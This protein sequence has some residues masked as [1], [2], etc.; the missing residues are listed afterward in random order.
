MSWS[1][2]LHF[3]MSSVSSVLVLSAGSGYDGLAAENVPEGNIEIREL[4]VHPAPE[5]VPALKY[6]L[7]PTLPDR[8]PGNA[9]VLY[10]RILIQLPNA[11]NE[12]TSEKMAKWAGADVPLEDLPL[13]ELRRTLQPLHSV[14]GELAIA[15]R[16][17]SCQWDVPFR[18][19]QNPFAVL[20]PELQQQ[21]QLARILVVNI[22]LAIREGRI[23]DA[24]ELLQTGFALARDVGNGPTLIH[25]LVGTAICGLLT[26]EIEELALQ[27]EGPNLYW[28]LTA[29]PRPLIDLRRGLETEMH[30]LDLWFPALRDIESTGNDPSFWEAKFEEIA[31]G[32]RYATGGPEPEAGYRALLTLLALKGYPKA[33]DYMVSRGY[34]EEEVAAMHTARV[35]LIAAISTY[36]EQRDASFKWLYLPYNE[37]RGGL[38]E[39]ENRFN[40]DGRDQEVLPLASMILPAIGA[41]KL[42]AA[43]HHRSLE[44]AR[45]IEAIRLHAATHNGRLPRSLAEITDVP[46]PTDPVW[47]KPFE[48]TTDGETVVIQ[49]APVPT[50]GGERHGLRVE[51]RLAR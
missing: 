46:V 19:G 13:A 27:T 12:E 4:T 8:T 6:Q 7:L 29:M 49:S 24:I 20:L 44:I 45:L 41:A 38:E 36:R 31:W 15:A 3:A 48:L 25:G 33:V 1:R 50:Q 2:I 32:F 5:P 22:R 18:E 11:M 40:R 30:V 23:D 26:G 21:R 51:V 28:A 14:M 42:A 34:S 47:G 39:W 16:R 9:A 35:L 37:A 43:R 10:N 17:E